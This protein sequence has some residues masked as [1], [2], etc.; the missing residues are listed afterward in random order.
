LICYFD[1]SALVKRYVNEEGSSLVDQMLR[2]NKP[3]T[4]RYSALEITSALS[5]RNR[6]G[7][8][9]HPD[10]KRTIEQLNLDLTKMIIVEVT[11]HV[12]LTAQKAIQKNAL[13][14][15]DALQLGSAIHL[16]QKLQGEIAFICFDS[17]LLIA[18]QTEGFIISGLNSI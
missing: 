1:A 13:R 14:A 7:D 15:G 17:N 11:S 2:K 3:A 18:A 6:M 5:R 10:Y 8:L 12:I 4:T 16:K 9:S